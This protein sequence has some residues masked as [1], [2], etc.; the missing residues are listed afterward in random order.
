MTSPAPPGGSPESRDASKSGDRF[1]AVLDGRVAAVRA[2]VLLAALGRGTIALVGCGC[3][4]AAFQQ[5]G[6]PLPPALVWLTAAAIAAT[7]AGRTPWPGRLET[8]RAIERAQ[9][10]LGE[11]VSRA[12]GLLPGGGQAAGPATGQAEPRPL[13]QQ[14]VERAAMDA[15]WAL[16]EAANTTPASVRAG[17]LWA[18]ASAGL[19]LVMAGTAQFLPGWRDAILVAVGIGG[20][21]VR[22][23]DERARPSPAPPQRPAAAAAGALPDAV[24]YGLA[25]HRLLAP[26]L[27]ARF[28][29][30]PGLPRADLPADEKD[31]LDR[32]ADLQTR[33]ADDLLKALAEERPPPGGAGSFRSFAEAQSAVL[34]AIPPAI[35]DNRLATAAS[36]TRA[37]LA[38]AEASGLRREPDGGSPLAT[39]GPLVSGERPPLDAGELAA[40]RLARLLE[41]RLGRKARAAE[42]PFGEAS[43]RIPRVP[44]LAARPDA[45]IGR[46]AEAGIGDGVGSSAADG[47]AAEESLPTA[48]PPP[49]GLS[50]RGETQRGRPTDPVGL[51][52]WA[53]GRDRPAPTRVDGLAGSLPA[54]DAAAVERYF[55][56]LSGDDDA[57]EPAAPR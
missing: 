28:A 53:A 1:L 17:R 7:L 37:F 20:R 44:A 12:V 47:L 56:I 4:A 16:A 45:A 43:E 49:G 9:P 57:C 25:V 54:T 14:L 55:L 5:A 33:L 31:W 22:D 18:G 40:A 52:A 3:L 46:G 21:P 26:E 30:R 24:A 2:G 42:P 50:G 15:S 10:S 34:A 36:H 13:A 48:T 32:A 38:A 27:M 51:E 8:A 35:R 6:L 39:L 41:P 11:R 19:L 23:S 29:H